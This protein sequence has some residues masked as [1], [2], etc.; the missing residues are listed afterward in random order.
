M[1]NHL[2]SLSYILGITFVFFLGGGMFGCQSTTEE[3]ILPK[4]TNNSL[5]LIN[6]TLKFQSLED[7]D[8]ILENQNTNDIPNFRSFGKSIDLILHSSDPDKRIT[9]K[10][11]NYVEELE[12]TILLDILDENGMFII[13]EY[14]YYL[15]FNRELVAVTNN[16][17]LKNDI[18]EGNFE[19]SSI[20]L[21]SFED[22]VLDLVLTNKTSTI[23]RS[24]IDARILNYNPNAP[25]IIDG[26]G[27]DKCSNNGDSQQNIEGITSNGSNFTYR[28]EAKHVYQAVGVYFRLFSEAKHMR[29]PSGSPLTWNSESTTMYVYYEYEYDSRKNSIGLRSGNSYA[30]VFS[31]QL[32]PTY[33][34]SNR[35]LRKFKLETQ[36]YVEIGG[37]HGTPLDGSIAWNFN[38]KRI[39]KGY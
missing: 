36:Y 13:E 17:S 6:G 14:L 33:Y 28:L 31:N 27:W 22:D 23:N 30:Y 4:L 10:V 20:R 38:L 1:K 2:K 12:G 34:E 16:F 25:T 18:L 24:E 19:D 15:D 32:K 35:S 39:I 3:E 21:F 9:E 37:N 8:Q 26:C 11:K 29:R 5:E 7:Y